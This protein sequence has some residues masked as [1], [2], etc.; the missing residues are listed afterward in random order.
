[1][2]DNGKRARDDEFFDAK[3]NGEFFDAIGNGEFFD[4]IVNEEF[5]DATVNQHQH[6]QHQQQTQQQQDHASNV[7]KTNDVPGSSNH[8]DTHGGAFRAPGVGMHS[9]NSDQVSC[10]SPSQ[11]HNSMPHLQAFHGGLHSHLLRN[12]QHAAAA[13]KRESAKA[14]RRK[15]RDPDSSSCSHSTRRSNVYPKRFDSMSRANSYRCSKTPEKTTGET[16]GI[17]INNTCIIL[18]VVNE[19][20]KYD[21]HKCQDTIVTAC[22]NNAQHVSAAKKYEKMKRNLSPHPKSNACRLQS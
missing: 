14:K 18:S 9:H 8:S 5:F 21:H 19:Q 20:T 7:G 6:Q 15:N 4:V 17:P 10:S 12:Q 22:T 3:D 13:T 11:Q 16:R 1:M 2:V